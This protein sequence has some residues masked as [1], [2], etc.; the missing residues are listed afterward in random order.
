MPALQKTGSGWPEIVADGC[1]YW[2][3]CCLNQILRSK[4]VLGQ[5][6]SVAP[7]RDLPTHQLSQAR[8]YSIYD[9]A[10]AEALP[11]VM[12]LQTAVRTQLNSYSSIDHA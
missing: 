12:C 9:A 1:S 7:R 3:D 11:V 5:A 4:C 8:S 6:L 2:T 10:G